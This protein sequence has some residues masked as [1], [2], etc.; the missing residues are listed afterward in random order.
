MNTLLALLLALLIICA[1]L[2]IIMHYITKWRQGRE[3]SGD[4]EQL[5]D[6]LWQMAQRIEDRV[7]TLEKILDDQENN[8]RSKT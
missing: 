5:L 2:A 7:E 6:E 3:I 1:P 4:D 8:W